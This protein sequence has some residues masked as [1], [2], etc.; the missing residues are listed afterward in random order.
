[1]SHERD[2]VDTF[3][4][5]RRDPVQ[6]VKDCFG[7]KPD[8]WQEDVLR[9]FPTH[10][11]ICMMACKG[12]GKSCLLAWL[13][14][15]FLFLYDDAK[16]ICTSVTEDNLKDGLWT[17][18]S[19]WLQR[20]PILSSQFIWRKTVVE[21]RDPGHAPT[22]YAVARPWSKSADQRKQSTGLAGKHADN[23]MFILD[24][25]GDIPDAIVATAEAALANESEEEGRVAKLVMAGNPT[26]KSGPLWRAVNQEK[27]LWHITHISGDPDD[28]KRSPRVSKEWARQQIKKYGRDDDY[29]RVNVFGKFPK[30]AFNAL[31]SVE[32]VE[33]AMRRSLPKEAYRASQK[34]LGIDVAG[35]GDDRTII[36][37]RQGKQAFKH[38]E[39]T[40]NHPETVAGRVLLAKARWKSEMEF[41]DNS[42]GY[43]TGV[44]T[45]VEAAGADPV[46]VGFGTKADDS[47]FANKRA[48]MWFRM[49]EWIKKGGCLPQD[50]ELVKELTEVRYKHRNGKFILESKDQIKNR[51]GFS[52][53]KAD[54]LALTFAWEELP[55][56]EWDDGEYERHVPRKDDEFDPLEYKV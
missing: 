46:P 56:Q 9:A 53:D 6:F 38:V 8:A 25:V 42:G 39:C 36:F 52:P 27:D 35:E 54:A 11:R 4:E 3:L 15:H 16:I 33:A 37:P 30:A 24:E 50:D 7:V 41:F 18:L 12:P 14:L 13:V 43:G 34:R 48:E 20:S 1:M 47:Q 26:Q 21:H 51:L 23:I 49:A 5:W 17:E 22:W 32:E 28:P 45:L 40:D 55:G 2:I 19:K 44:V 31:L 10:M 29:V